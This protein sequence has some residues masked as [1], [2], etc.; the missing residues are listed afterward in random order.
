MITVTGLQGPTSV[1]QMQ[2]VSPRYNRVDGMAYNVSEPA[3]ISLWHCLLTRSPAAAIH[4]LTSCLAG[5]LRCAMLCDQDTYLRHA[6]GAFIPSG[7]TTLGRSFVYIVSGGPA[8]GNTVVTVF[9]R[10]K[11][12]GS[13]TAMVFTKTLSMWPLIAERRFLGSHLDPFFVELYPRSDWE[14]RA[15]WFAA[16]VLAQW[17]I[18]LH[19]G[20]R[21]FAPSSIIVVTQSVTPALPC[22]R[23]LCAHCSNDKRLLVLRCD[24]TQ[25]TFTEAGFLQVEADLPLFTALPMLTQSAATAV[26]V[27]VQPNR[28]KVGCLVRRFQFRFHLQG[29]NGLTLILLP[30]QIVEMTDSGTLSAPVLQWIERSSDTWTPP[31]ALTRAAQV[32]RRA[33]F[34]PLLLCGGCRKPH[35]LRGLGAAC[36]CA[37]ISANGLHLYT[38]HQTGDNKGVI[39]VHALLPL[40]FLQAADSVLSSYDI[41]QLGTFVCLRPRHLLLLLFLLDRTRTCP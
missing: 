31:Y 13:I 2:F 27:V 5:V 41:S 7:S 14:L 17:R 40:Q 9:E 4:S 23:V 37:Q 35:L 36:C 21:A 10:A 16:L 33:L 19:S 26:L 6:I 32:G 11:S 28:I 29:V 3:E 1:Q 20:V 12:G 30:T 34:L 15:S 22:S 39:K 18:L 8:T 38:A 24:H 25:G